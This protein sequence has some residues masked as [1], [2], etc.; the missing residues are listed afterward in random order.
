MTHAVHAYV[1]YGTTMHVHRSVWFSTLMILMFL[2]LRFP[3]T[4]LHKP[5]D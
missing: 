4:A 3:E 5:D 1:N 2:C